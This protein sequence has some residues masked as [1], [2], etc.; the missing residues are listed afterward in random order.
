MKRNCLINIDK[1]SLINFIN[2][3]SKLNIDAKN[4]I[5]ESEDNN[6]LFNIRILSKDKFES[7]LFLNEK[8]KEAFKLTKTNRFI[9]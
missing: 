9:E 2:V 5:F 1:Y 7:S 4:Q 6:M 3:L 8:K